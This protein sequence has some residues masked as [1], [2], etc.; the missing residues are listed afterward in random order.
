MQVEK[1]NDLLKGIYIG[2]I[3]GDLTGE[4]E[5]EFKDYM[6]MHHIQTG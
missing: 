6:D 1:Q 2:S 4:Y 5:F 3:V